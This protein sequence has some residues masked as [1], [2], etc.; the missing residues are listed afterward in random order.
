MN[1]VTQERLNQLIEFVQDEGRVCPL[2]QKWNELWNL[3]P[4]RRVGAGW[5]PAL[6]LILAAWWES[7]AAQKRNRLADHIRFAAESG[8]LD[9][10]EQC[11]RNLRPDEWAYGDGT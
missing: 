9:S 1:T 6:P 4:A 3:L 10:V 5:E 11:L 8:V 2:P 7:S